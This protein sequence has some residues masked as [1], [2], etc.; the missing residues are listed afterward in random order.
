VLW[1]KSTRGRCGGSGV[2]DASAGR[3]QPVPGRRAR[4][5]PGIRASRCAERRAAV[6][7]GRAG[8]QRRGPV[9]AGQ[10]HRRAE[11]L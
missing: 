6:A 3:G 2:A 8:H 5:P 7:T 1:K 11:D 10:G 4:G 9:R